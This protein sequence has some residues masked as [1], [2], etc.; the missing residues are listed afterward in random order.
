MSTTKTNFRRITTK[1]I[2]TVE[3][4]R[5][6]KTSDEKVTLTVKAPHRVVKTPEAKKNAVLETETTTKTKA[7]EKEEI[8]EEVLATD[9]TLP[10]AKEAA[11]TPVAEAKQDKTT[12]KRTRRSK[13]VFTENSNET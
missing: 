5:G 9:T 2:R 10:T 7:Q 11:A 3:V 6:R 13:R 12:N 1:R 8:N 4:P